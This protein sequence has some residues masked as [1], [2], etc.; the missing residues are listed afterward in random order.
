MRTELNHRDVVA[1]LIK[2]TWRV[3]RSEK[4]KLVMAGQNLMPSQLS[5]SMT[6]DDA[7]A[8]AYI[9]SGETAINRAKSEGVIK[10]NIYEEAV[11]GISAEED[12]QI[13]PFWGV[14]APARGSG[15]PFISQFPAPSKYEVSISDS[16]PEEC[17]ES[18]EKLSK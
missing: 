4:I 11:K 7:Y 5:S 16:R 2:F 12:K 15:Q 13:N 1:D 9:C 17:R 14:F 18:T 8:Q 10:A 3:G 6:K